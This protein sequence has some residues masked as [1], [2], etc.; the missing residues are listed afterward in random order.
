MPENENEKLYTGTSLKPPTELVPA[1]T[2]MQ[3]WM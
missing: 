2:V 3:S 1:Q